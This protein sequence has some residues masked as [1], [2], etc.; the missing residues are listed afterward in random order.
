MSE[1]LKAT[2]ELGAR[3]ATHPRVT[4][5]DIE[6][7]IEREHYFTAGDAIVAGGGFAPPGSPLNLLTIC[8]LEMKNGFTQLGESAPASPENFD[9]VKGK[10]FAKE[11]AIRALWP[12]MGYALRDRLHREAVSE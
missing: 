10:T 6:D 2:E 4:L 3:G 7:Q 5:Q 11:N 12:R 9:A 8:V 1:S